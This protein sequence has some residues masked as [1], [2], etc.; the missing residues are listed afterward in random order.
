MRD[1]VL[2]LFEVKGLGSVLGCREGGGCGRGRIGQ[3]RGD[4][5]MHL[6]AAQIIFL[7]RYGGC[8][9]FTVSVAFK[10]VPCLFITL[11]LIL[12]RRHLRNR[13]STLSNP[14]L[15]ILTLQVKDPGEDV[16]IMFKVRAL[17]LCALQKEVVGWNVVYLKAPKSG[18]IR[19]RAPVVNL[20]ALRSILES[21]WLAY[22]NLSGWE[23]HP[24]TI[25]I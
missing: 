13:C 1:R 25:V 17:L 21:H 18:A 5:V 8:L 9:S 6:F 23:V 19:G 12:R 7:A 10:L 24:Q 20:Q 3:A 15:W 14:P 22:G 16:T 11:C 2:G 4:G